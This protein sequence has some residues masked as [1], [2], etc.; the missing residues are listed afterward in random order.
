MASQDIILGI[1]IGTTG[2]KCIF[3]TFDGS[4]AAQA[5]TEYK[6]VVPQNG[7]SEQNPDVWWQAV[8]SN[9]RTCFISEKAVTPDRVAVIGISCTNAV[10]LVD[11]DGNA[12]YNAITLHDKRASMQVEWLK[13]KV[14][15][16]EVVS[17]SKNRLDKGTFALP[18]IR[19]LIDNRPDIIKNC[20]KFLMPSGYIIQKLTGEFS[21]NK[22]RMDLT[23]LSNMTAGTWDENICAKAEIPMQLLPKVY[24]STDIVGTVTKEA[25]ELTGLKIG[26][27]VNAGAVDTIAA[28]V[29][30]GAVYFGD[31]AVTIGSSG[32]ICTVEKEPVQDTRLLNISSGVL[33][34]TVIVQTTDN[35]GISLKWFRDNFTSLI[36]PDRNKSIYQILDE[37]AE[38]VKVTAENLIYLPYLSGEK[39]PIW[40][41]HA[42]GVFF[43]IGLNASLG[44]FVRAILEGVA[45][46][47]R[48]CST[49]LQNSFSSSHEIPLG[50]GAAK[51]KL[52]CQIFADVLNKTVIQ[53]KIND[54]ETLGD[55]IIAAQAIGIKEIP[56]DFGKT[57][58]VKGTIIT[59]IVQNVAVYDVLFQKYKEVYLRLKD[60]FY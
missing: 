4:I 33:D 21:I 34:N 58:A 22:S 18:T 15:E 39:C 36:Q 1:D 28:T 32:R 49:L 27:P 37:A 52:W 42:K 25:A 43:N 57:L 41:P 12:L 51:S 17:S 11:R 10:T 2:T 8:I 60:C 38:S 40:D 55:M 14:G 47:I 23:S 6:T 44:S 56:V 5:Y 20:Y 26:T 9:I 13:N 24:R 31:S 19:W 3:Y 54:T 45:F 46:S 50:G 7:W 48:D 35:A 16:E 29:G 53:L 30:A 59:P